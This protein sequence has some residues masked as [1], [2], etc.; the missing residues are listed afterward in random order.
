MYLAPG[1]KVEL[2][3]SQAELRTATAAEAAAA[4]RLAQS[5]AASAAAE[6]AKA[7][8]TAE[9]RE[10]KDAVAAAERFKA[11]LQKALANLKD[12]ILALEAELPALEEPEASRRPVFDMSCAGGFVSRLLV[13]VVPGERSLLVSPELVAF[14]CTLLNR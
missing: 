4:V 9:V 5:E 14:G 1:V 8:L 11:D 3:Q 13:L 10:S 6:E 2:A 12:R 7:E